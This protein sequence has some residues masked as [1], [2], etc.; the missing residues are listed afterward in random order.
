[1]F[2]FGKESRSKRL[3]NHKVAKLQDIRNWFIPVNNESFKWP[4]PHTQIPMLS[5]KIVEAMFQIE[6][7]KLSSSDIPLEFCPWRP[8]HKNNLGS[9]MG[10]FWMSWCTWLW[11]RRLHIAELFCCSCPRKVTSPFS[12][13]LLSPGC[14]MLQSLWNTVRDWESILQK[15]KLKTM[16]FVTL[17]L[18]SWRICPCPWCLPKYN[19]QH[20]L[21][22]PKSVFFYIFGLPCF[23]RCHTHHFGMLINYQYYTNQRLKLY[24]KNLKLCERANPETRCPY[25]K[26]RES[27]NCGVLQMSN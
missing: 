25:G 21:P 26:I 19:N 23:N 11:H 8:F 20:F 1:M 16:T 3:K 24:D 5:E 12:Q 2:R 7:G 15:Y 9:H 10:T 17:W 6:P 27:A 13:K 22:C 4:L 18:L 14:W